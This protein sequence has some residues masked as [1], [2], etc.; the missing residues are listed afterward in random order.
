MGPIERSSGS[1]CNPVPPTS[2][3]TGHS[4]APKKEV[5]RRHRGIVNIRLFLW[6]HH[7]ME[8]HCPFLYQREILNFR[9]LHS[10]IVEWL[11]LERLW[12]RFD[13]HPKQ[14]PNDQRANEPCR[15]VLPRAIDREEGGFSSTPGNTVIE[16]SGKCYKLRDDGMMKILPLEFALRYY[17]NT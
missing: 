3:V 5:R 11:Q 4:K 15:S 16:R 12:Q 17:P 7:R 1:I 8:A 10:P 13:D 6:N 9:I 14:Y 2:V